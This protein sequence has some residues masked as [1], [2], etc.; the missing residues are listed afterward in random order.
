MSNAC[1][2][3]PNEQLLNGG[4]LGGRDGGLAQASSELSQWLT[5]SQTHRFRQT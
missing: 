5:T 1:E 2:A 4:T 3:A